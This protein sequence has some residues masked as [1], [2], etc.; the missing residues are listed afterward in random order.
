LD[1]AYGIVRRTG[2]LLAECDALCIETR[3]WLDKRD[4]DRGNHCVDRLEKLIA[5]TGYQL[6]TFDLS[7]L[8]A[9][10]AILRDQPD[11][12]RAV[13]AELRQKTRKI[14][15]KACDEDIDFLSAL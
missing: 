15:Y 7:L 1:D 4:V 10:I 6:R 8:Q 11:H 13:L 9:W 3:L 12:G 2:N 14:G 5:T